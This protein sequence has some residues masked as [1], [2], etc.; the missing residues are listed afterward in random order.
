MEG[1]SLSASDE[2]RSLSPISDELSLSSEDSGGV[3]MASEIPDLIVNTMHSLNSLS[4]V[5]HGLCKS[6]DL[7]PKEVAQSICVLMHF[8]DIVTTTGLAA[9][10]ISWDNTGE[11]RDSL[12]FS[13]HH[14]LSSICPD[15]A[16]LAGTASE[17]C[18]EAETASSCPPISEGALTL[19]RGKEVRS[20][21][22]DASP[23]ATTPL[24]TTQAH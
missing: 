7:F 12:T 4:Q 13:Y 16:H 3:I 20:P 2:M 5:L 9:E 14:L 15:R 22:L 23:G 21:S 1:L 19:D 24:T 11:V 18:P 10:C 17:Q 6:I 8:M